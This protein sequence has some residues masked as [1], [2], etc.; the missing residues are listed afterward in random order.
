MADP[1]ATAEQAAELKLALADPTYIPTIHVGQLPAGAR[2][3]GWNAKRSKYCRAKAGWGTDHFGQGRCKFHRGRT[4]IK[5][6][7]YSKVK[8]E[9]LGDLIAQME[10]DPDPL[11]VLSELAVARALL[12]DWID[13]HADLCDALIQWNLELG[14]FERP[15]R[16]PDIH[17]VMPLLEGISKAVKRIEDVRSSNAISRPDL[18]RLMH[19]LARVVEHHVPD[20]ETRRRIRDGWLSVRT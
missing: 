1:P 14:D 2:C 15:K 6:G 10:A 9:Q 4:P 3:R 7:R 13:R 12:R 5:H 8:R 17:E 11:N 16:I 18:A 20:E 19:E